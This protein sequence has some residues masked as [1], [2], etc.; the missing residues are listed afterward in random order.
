MTEQLKAILLNE[1]TDSII[2]RQL[3]EYLTRLTTFKEA[4][5][6]SNDDLNMPFTY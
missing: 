3:D 4:V 5:D 1:V 6:H 2:E